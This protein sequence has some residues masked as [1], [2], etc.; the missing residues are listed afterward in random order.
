[1]TNTLPKYALIA[2]KDFHIY[3]SGETIKTKH[4][5]DPDSLFDGVMYNYKN[6][7]TVIVQ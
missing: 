7:I 6:C 3:K 4:T 1:M 2:I 5:N